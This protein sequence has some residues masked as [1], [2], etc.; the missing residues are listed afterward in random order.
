MDVK[1]DFKVSAPSGNVLSG[2]PSD[3]A[4]GSIVC[5]NTVISVTP[6]TSSTTYKVSSIYS[7]YPPGVGAPPACSGS[8]ST[9][10][11]Y[12]IPSGT[13]N[14]VKT[15]A[16]SNN[17]VSTSTSD[18]SPLGGLGSFYD[19]CMTFDDG[20]KQFLKAKGGARIFGKGTVVYK[21]GSTTFHTTSIGGS[22]VSTR[23]LTSLGA[24]S[25]SSSLSNV[26][27]MPIVNTKT[28]GVNFRLYYFWQLPG[29]IHVQNNWSCY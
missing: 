16:Q 4:S 7:P 6:K 5:P 18:L 13:Y 29:N 3:L 1:N 9:H 12:W 27:T 14:S 23:T 10:T 21:D 20:G 17:D 26:D 19:E 25:I 8:S 2:N 22:S 28:S 11:I 15:K 24:H